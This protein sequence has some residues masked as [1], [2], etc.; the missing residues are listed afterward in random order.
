MKRIVPSR[1]RRPARPDAAH[2]GRLREI[3]AIA[4]QEG[5]LSGER[6]RVIRGRMPPALVA[7]AKDRTGI[8]SD[9]DLIEIALANIA[10]ADEYAD[11]LLRERGTI[12]REVDLEF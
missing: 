1:R 8:A 7:K 9:T 12:S 6:T 11:W 4:E 3:M 10:V 2:P 5:L